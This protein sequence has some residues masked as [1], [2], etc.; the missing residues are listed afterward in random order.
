MAAEIESWSI[1]RGYASFA[2]YPSHLLGRFK[3]RRVVFALDGL[4]DVSVKVPLGLKARRRTGGRTKWKRTNSLFEQESA[5]LRDKRRFFHRLAISY[6][7]R[8]RFELLRH[9]D[10]VLKQSNWKKLFLNCLLFRLIWLYF[11]IAVYCGH[12]F[13]WAKLRNVYSTRSTKTR[14]QACSQLRI[15][16]SGRESKKELEAISFCR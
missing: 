7:K 2:I 13:V 3:A 8:F 5:S 16:Q 10:T 11:T 14:A 6:I 1:D 12:C 9:D 15:R 4:D